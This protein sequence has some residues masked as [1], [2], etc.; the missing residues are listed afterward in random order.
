MGFKGGSQ[1]ERVH[2]AFEKLSWAFADA[3]SRAMALAICL[4]S[5]CLVVLTGSCL[6]APHSKEAPVKNAKWL[7]LISV[8]LRIEKKQFSASHSLQ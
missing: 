7:K 3:C 5:V 8:V 1:P 4:L 2:R 6:F